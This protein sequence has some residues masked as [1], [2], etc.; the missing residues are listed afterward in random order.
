MSSEVLVRDSDATRLVLQADC[1]N[2]ATC[3]ELRGLPQPSFRF[4]IW[5]TVRRVHKK[6]IVGEQ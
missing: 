5:W 4:A 6:H 1:A 3:R 2:L